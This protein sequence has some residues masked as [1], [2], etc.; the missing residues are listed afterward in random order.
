MI[1]FRLI[2]ARLSYRVMLM[3]VMRLVLEVVGWQLKVGGSKRCTWWVS[4]L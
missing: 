2:S 3:K 4:W 1:C